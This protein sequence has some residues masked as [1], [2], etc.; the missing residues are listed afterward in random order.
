MARWRWPRERPTDLGPGT[1]QGVALRDEYDATKNGALLDRSVEILRATAVAARYAEAL[2]AARGGLGLSLR[3]RALVNT[4]EASSRDLAAAVAAHE[5]AYRLVPHD[6]QHRAGNAGNLAGTLRQ[7]WSATGNIADLHRSLELYREAVA[8]VRPGSVYVAD[9]YTNLA[10]G[11]SDQFDTRGNRRDLDD[12]VAAALAG[13]QA[14][15]PD[16]RALPRRLGIAAGLLGPHGT[17]LGNRDEVAKAVPLA[18][19]ACDLMS[20]EHSY[21]DH[22]SVYTL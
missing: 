19:R 1:R 21:I 16:S 8:T 10:N 15:P 3:E 13:V 18:T 11:L 2:R 7:R 14:T 4:G 20:P 5:E 22:S 6:S 12:A 17:L 9:A